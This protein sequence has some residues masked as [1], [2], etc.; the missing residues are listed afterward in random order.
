MKQGIFLN[1]IT[2]R[3]HKN[4]DILKNITL[5]IHQ[6]EFICILGKNGSGKTTLGY[7]L[8]GI[9]PHSF[10]GKLDGSITING[11]ETKQSSIGEIAKTIGTIA[12]DPDLML[13]NMTVYE[14]IAF[15]INNLELDNVEERIREALHQVGL[16]GFEKRDP[17]TLSEGQKQL[18]CIACTLAMG[19][20]ILLLDEPISHL[21]YINGIQVYELLKQLHKDGKTIIIIEHETDVVW[22]YAERV[23]IIEEGSIVADGKAQEILQQHEMLKQYGIKPTYKSHAK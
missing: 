5:T 4:H 12:Q 13:F 21:D 2:Y 3:Y 17:N 22:D 8:N 6:G 15:G 18:L 11:E 16:T 10:A 1:N 23:L 9:I 20:E 19:T 14:E 7:C